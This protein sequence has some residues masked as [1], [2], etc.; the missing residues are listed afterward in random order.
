MQPTLADF[1][2]RENVKEVGGATLYGV[3]QWLVSFK[4]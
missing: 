2:L 3:Q 4:P 1:P